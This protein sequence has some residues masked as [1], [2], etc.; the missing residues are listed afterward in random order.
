MKSIKTKGIIFISSI[1]VT[2][3]IVIL[4]ISHSLIKD[5]A[6][7][8]KME[9]IKMTTKATKNLTER[10]I[11]NYVLPIKELSKISDIKSMDWDKQRE[12]IKKQKGLDYLTI[13]IVDKEGTAH[14]PNGNTLDLSDRGYIKKS[15]NGEFNISPVLTSRVTRRPVMMIAQPIYREGRVVGSIIARLNPKFLTEFIGAESSEVYNIYFVLNENG[16]IVLHSEEEYKSRHYNFLTFQEKNYGYE[17]FKSIIKK[18]YNL[19]NG[20]GS[21]IK[22]GEKIYI[23]YSNIESLNWRFYLGFYEKNALK[24]L[25]HLDFIF[26]MIGLICSVI[27]AMI[28]WFITKSFTQPVIEMSN[29][30][31]KAAEGDLTVKSDYNKDDELGKASKSFNKMMDK[32]RSLTYFDPVTDLR[33]EQVLRKDFKEN[34]EKEK[35]LKKNI[36]VIQI[37]KFSKINEMFGYKKADVLLKL[38]SNKILEILPNEANLYKG[39][40]EQFIIF[41]E[42]EVIDENLAAIGENIIKRFENPI[43][44]ENDIVN[45]DLKIGI[46]EFS[47]DGFEIENLIKKAVFASNSTKNKKGKNIL[48]FKEELYDE[49]LE[50]QNLIKKIKKAIKND[51]M[52]L[53]F[54]PIYGLKNMTVKEIEVLIRW[55]DADE[56]IISPG[57]FI[58][59]AEENDLISKI[60]FWVI[61]KALFQIKKWKVAGLSLV[62]ISINISSDTFERNDFEDYLVELSNYYEIE[63]EYIQLELTERTF[64]NDIDKTINKFKR[65]RKKGFK[66][67]IDDFGVGYSSLSYLVKLPID[68]LKIDKSFIK[69]INSSNQA[70]TI[71]STLVDMGMKL[72]VE[73]ISEGIETKEELDY[74][75]DIKCDNGQ[76]YLMNKPL[77]FETMENILSENSK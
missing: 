25:K 5:W 37:N 22:D 7:E 20:L 28:A 70:K 68:Y 17:G 71:V 13:A 51:E 49:N 39:K 33:N 64:L 43:K 45:I 67:A 73:V 76:G 11:S 72:D 48:F 30:F 14:Y 32:I 42:D 41:F 66:I 23:G 74:L 35:E 46:S 38:I 19:D 65:L 2:V 53:N 26:I 75:L 54:Q 77:D 47:K 60:D 24:N 4:L 56:G 10:Y 12:I 52:F 1:L 55:E 50:I 36:M 34:I 58:P 61:K 8:Q 15:L 9:N 63:N 3:L 29:L 62:P 21:F 27:L 31:K 59:V 18:S 6:I 44:M 40:N 16:N 57:K 69:D